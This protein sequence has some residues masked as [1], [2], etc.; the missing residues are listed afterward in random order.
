M[1]RSL[2]RPAVGGLE[3]PARGL[4]PSFE[5]FEANMH[6]IHLQLLPLFRSKD[7][8]EGVQPFLE[9]R[10]PEFEGR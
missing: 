3:D 10:T 7:F 9:K 6:H 1:L 4:I 5:T 8:N 2:Q